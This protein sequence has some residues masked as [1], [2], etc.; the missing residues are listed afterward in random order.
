MPPP[1]ARIDLLAAPICVVPTSIQPVFM[2]RLAHRSAQRC[3]EHDS[4]FSLSIRWTLL[5]M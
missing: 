4:D 3:G 1:L 2:L 5:A